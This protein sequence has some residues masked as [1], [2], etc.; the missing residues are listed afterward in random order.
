[1]G[2]PLRLPFAH[3]AVSLAGQGGVLARYC[4]ST[5]QFGKQLYVFSSIFS[6]AF[7]P[8]QRRTRLSVVICG[9][10]IGCLQQV[11]RKYV[12]HVYDFSHCVWAQA[13][14]SSD[15]ATKLLACGRVMQ[16]EGRGVKW[17]LQNAGPFARHDDHPLCL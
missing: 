13:K 8:F 11:S 2:Y 12:T 9:R 16:E 6:F 15:G 14:A 10:A 4:G 7:L 5:Q 1:L 17:L 3:D